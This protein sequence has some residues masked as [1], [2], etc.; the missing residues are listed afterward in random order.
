MNP[1]EKLH[2]FA[3]DIILKKELSSLDPDFVM[4]KLSAV[5]ALQKFRKAK[6][7]FDES[8]YK[9]FSRS[10]EH[11]AIVK[12][13]RVDLRKLYGVF[14]NNDYGKRKKL[15]EELKEDSSVEAH[16]K[17]LKLHRSSN[18]RLGSYG[19]AYGQIFEITGKPKKILDL[20]CGLNPLSY[21]YLECEP[22]YIASDLSEEDMK[23]IDAYFKIMKI[24]GKAVFLDLVKAKEEELAKLSKDVDITFLFKALDSMEFVEW[25]SSK[26][27]ISS[28]KSKWIVVSFPTKSIGGKKPIKKEKR[29]WFEKFL[30]EKELTSTI[31]ELEDEIFYV[32]KNN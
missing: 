32:I 2:A 11:D 10:K 8:D 7:K 22:E 26:R 20:A 25:N 9:Q 27:I 1:D 13:V 3:R 24:K 19:E 17:L 12:E 23:F 15:L 4:D 28:L 31:F 14:I 16:N 6:Q 29:G 5:L 21:P 18:E 30:E